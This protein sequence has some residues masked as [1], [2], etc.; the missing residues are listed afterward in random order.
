MPD[1][2]HGMNAYVELDGQDVSACWATAELHR[3]IEEADTTAFQQGDRTFIAGLH[4]AEFPIAGMFDAT[5]AQQITGYLGID[6]QL[7]VVF[8]PG[9][10]AVGEPKYVFDVLIDEFDLQIPVGDKVKASG[11]AKINGTVQVTTF[12]GGGGG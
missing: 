9:G 12:S 3:M 8:G 2:R 7:T 10:S 11:S 4:G 5:V 1:F 6:D